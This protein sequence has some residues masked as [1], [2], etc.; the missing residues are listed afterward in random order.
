METVLNRVF[1]SG[2]AS[3]AIH[4]HTQYVNLMSNG[5]SNWWSSQGPGG[6]ENVWKNEKKNWCH[7]IKGIVKIMAHRLG[8]CDNNNNSFSRPYLLLISNSIG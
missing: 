6:L 1:L 2:F 8:T 5:Y 7:S 3:S 4:C